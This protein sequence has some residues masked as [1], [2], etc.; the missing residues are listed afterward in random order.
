MTEHK[1][2]KGIFHIFFI[3][4]AFTLFIQIDTNAQTPVPTP[5]P[6]PAVPPVTELPN[7]DSTGLPES[8]P[9]V[10]PDYTAPLRPLPSMERVGVSSAQQTTMS[11][12][13][14]IELALRNSNDIETSQIDVKI[15]EFGLKGSRGLYDPRFVSEHYYM[16]AKV[17]S[18]SSLGGPDG[19]TS[20]TGVVNSF[21]ISGQSP[22]AGGSYSTS[23]RMSR[24]Q[25]NNPLNTFDPQYPSSFNFTYTQPIFR[26]LTT[27]NTRRQIEIAKKNLS[28]SDAQF[29]QRSIDVITNVTQSYW[30]L[31]YALRNLQVQIDAVKQ[32]RAQVESNRR[33]VQE[34]TIAP[35]EIVEAEAQV[36]DFEQA[37]YQAQ[38]AV[39]QAENELKTIL[40]ADSNDALWTSSIVPT[41]PIFIEPPRVSVED[42]LAEARENR[43]ELDRLRASQEI[44]KINTK[45][46][47]DRTRPQIDLY[48]SVTSNGL[49]G[50][51]KENSGGLFS[52]F[53]PLYDR[54][55]LLSAQQNLPPLV[56]STSGSTVPPQFVGGYGT[57][58]SNLY[59]FNYPTYQFG[60][61]IELPFGNRT[62]KADLGAALATET[63]TEAQIAQT[64]QLIK[65]EVQNS[66]QAMRAAEARVNAAAASRNS[67]EQLYESEKRKLENGTSTVYLVLQ[68]QQNLVNAR[69]REL[70]A[71]TDLNKAIANFHR[72]V[73]STFDV[74][75][76]KFS[77]GQ[78]L[79]M[80][81]EPEAGGDSA[82]WTRSNPRNGGSPTLD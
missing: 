46:F 27:D 9:N 63:K 23:F 38:Q 79:R 61:R 3:L 73:G 37:V 7:L 30:S 4:F 18:A 74:Y 42:A 69:A 2:S 55:N 11:L 54:V 64:D 14:A 81:S 72:S 53:G 36:T 20:T 70:Q 17:P 68:R 44:N 71:Q 35:I 40:L 33:Q 41:T 10:A 65:A 5:T 77:D 25:S 76:I 59:K 75:N 28:L 52:Q 12:N 60:V 56:I 66:L 43:P 16:D 82:G 47:R 34:G 26:G 19:S 80:T 50:R 21:G 39:T 15:A 32:A 6:V 31:T 58:F 57:S 29:R 24:E 78:S 13:D 51:E 48:A 1:F 62:A 8:I 67:T 49:A 22:F 45:Y